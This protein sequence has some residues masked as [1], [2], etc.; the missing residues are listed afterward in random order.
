MAS[1]PGRFALA[2]V[3]LAALL[4]GAAARAADPQPAAADQ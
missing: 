3:L 4:C 2:A 1:D